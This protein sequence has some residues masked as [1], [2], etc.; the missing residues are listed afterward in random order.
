MIGFF[1]IATGFLTDRV[2]AAR[3]NGSM[4]E[5]GLAD[6]RDHVIEQLSTGFAANT[7]ELDELERRLALAH[8]AST[9]AELDALVTDLAPVTSQAI[10]PAK[11]MRVVL[12]SVERSGRW[13]VPQQLTARVLW[14]NLVVDLRDAQLPPGMTTIDVHITMGNVEIIV[15][16]GVDVDVDASSLLANVEERTVP[17]ASTS[18]RV[19]VTGR[20]ALGNLEISTL[21][22]GETK[23]DSRRRRRWERRMQRRMLRHSYMRRLPMPPDHDHW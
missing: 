2:G 13:A 16:P 23:R 10:V 15:P 19:R 11:R 18:A 21:R 20:V 1:T 14:G 22:P 6:R 17:A 7:F 12:G 5:P 8:S 3:Y 9:P 4:N